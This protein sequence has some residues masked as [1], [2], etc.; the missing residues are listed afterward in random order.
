[1]QC[2]VVQRNIND[3]RPIGYLCVNCM[4]QL[5]ITITIAPDIIFNED[6]GVVG[7]SLS[8]IG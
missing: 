7:I 2:V 3:F 4:L 5:C 8:V 6:L 1:M